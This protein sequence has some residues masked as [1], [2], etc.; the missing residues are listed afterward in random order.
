MNNSFTY[1]TNYVMDR[2]GD[3]TEIVAHIIS[4]SWG[5]ISNIRTKDVI[6]DYFLLLVG[7]DKEGS[8]IFAHPNYSKPKEL[9]NTAEPVQVDKLA[10]PK[11]NKTK[12]AKVKI[13]KQKFIFFVSSF[14]TFADCKSY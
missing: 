1:S 10:A 8:F 13:Y 9:E 7:I 14:V 2:T 11:V 6:S 5:K 12:P 3:A 4:E